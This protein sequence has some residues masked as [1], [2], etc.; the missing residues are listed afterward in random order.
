MD[1]I[2]IFYRVIY[3]D[4]CMNAAIKHCKSNNQIRELLGM[5]NGWSERVYKYKGNKTPPSAPVVTSVMP[6]RSWNF[7]PEERESD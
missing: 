6:V 5:L 2:K 4:W 1:T 7:I 3:G